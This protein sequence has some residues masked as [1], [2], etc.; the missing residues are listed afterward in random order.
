MSTTAS[1]F[2]ELTFDETRKEIE[3]D[4]LGS[5]VEAKKWT[6]QLVGGGEHG[7]T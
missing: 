2:V 1:T 4:E 6:L 7:Q 5:K 3:D